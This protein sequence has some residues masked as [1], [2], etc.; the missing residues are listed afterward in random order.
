[1]Q[2]ISAC[3]IDCSRRKLTT[4]NTAFVTSSFGYSTLNGGNIKAQSF[5]QITFGVDG[6]PCLV[7][8]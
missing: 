1:M 7:R 2:G 6:Q 5:K 4:P 8:P 3:R